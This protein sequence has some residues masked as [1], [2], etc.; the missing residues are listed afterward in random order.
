M[1]ISNETNKVKQKKMITGISSIKIGR[2]PSLL[3]KISFIACMLAEIG[4]FSLITLASPDFFMVVD[5]NIGIAVIRKVIMANI[6]AFLVETRAVEN[7]NAIE[8]NEIINT[9]PIPYRYTRIV[10]N[11][12]APYDNTYR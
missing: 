8:E 4:L 9:V 11:K 6:I 5:K 2:E 3:M 12:F 1:A 10:K 7:I